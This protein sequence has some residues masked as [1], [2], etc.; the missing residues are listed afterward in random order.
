MKRA[1]LINALAVAALLTC[2]APLQAADE[3]G[4][5][6]TPLTAGPELTALPVAVWAEAGGDAWHAGE[7]TFKAE[8]EAADASAVGWV[9]VN[10]KAILIRIAVGD[11]RHVGKSGKNMW[12][13]DCIQLGVIPFWSGGKPAPPDATGM[14]KAGGSFCFSLTDNGPYTWVYAHSGTWGK[15]RRDDLHAAVTRDV[16]AKT[17]TYDIAIPWTEFGLG[18]AC[19][20]VLGVTVQVNDTDPGKEQERLYWGDG[21]GG[22]FDPGKFKWLR[23]GSPAGEFAGVTVTNRMLCEAHPAAESIVALTSAR[24]CTITVSFAGAKQ[25]LAVKARP[26]LRFFSVKATPARPL[27]GSAAFATTVAAAGGDAL[28][29]AEATV[30]GDYEGPWYAFKPD[31]DSGPSAIGMEDWLE[32]PAGVHGGVRMV[33]DHFEFDDGTRVKFWGLNHSYG[34]CAP[35]KGEADRRA[36]HYRKYGVNCIRL[37]KFTNYGNGIGAEETVTK[38][39]PEGLE[40]LDYYH[41]QL[42]KN[43]IYTGWSSIFALRLRPGDKDS[44]PAFDEV[45][46]VTKDNRGR[47]RVKGS[48]MGY[49]FINRAIQ[50]LHIQQTVNLLNHR[51]PHTGLTYADDPVLA[52][53]EFHN[54]DDIFWYSTSNMIEANPA[55]KKMFCEQF[56]DWLKK[57]YG[58]HAGLVEAWGEN[59]INAFPQWMKGEHLDKRNIYPVSNP[60]FMG[61]GVLEGMMKPHKRRILDTALFMYEQQLD[62]YRRYETAIRATGFKGS[63]VGS[64]WRAG[65]GVP[66]YYNLHT[67]YLVGHIDRHDYFGGG[68]GGH[69]SFSPNSMLG[70]PGS[71]LLAEGL[72]QVKDR[73]FALSEWINVNPHEW[74]AEG[75]AIIGVYAMGL[76]GWDASYEFNSRGAGFSEALGGRWDTQQPSAIGIYPAI[77]RMVL[78]GDVTEADVISARKVHVPSLAEGKL[79]FGESVIEGATHD[80]KTFTSDVPNRALAVGRV[81]VEFTKEYEPTDLT[82]IS[83]Y[84]NGNVTKSTTGELTWVVPAPPAGGLVAMSY[85]DP[86]GYFTVNAAGTKAVVGFAPKQPFKLGDVTITVDNLFAVVFVTSLEKDKGIADAGRLLVT[87]IARTKNTGMRRNAS[88]TEL[89]ER[90]EG[91]ILM[92]P[93]RAD[94]RLARL[95]RMAVNI[96]DHDGRRTG[97]TLP[98]SDG[99]FSIDGARDKTMYYEIVF[100]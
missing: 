53:V 59:S 62:F 60:W 56:S 24:D 23:P 17:T 55:H 52:Y 48:T 72:T 16:N 93:V 51:N 1:L 21:I 37:H 98:V 14:G 63:L 38:F 82:D 7:P 90:G 6:I 43:G 33:G 10:S 61:Q 54:E 73:P 8:G 77:S 32:A 69:T 42:K 18:P 40:R 57:K 99:G 31:N 86:Q 12:Q 58:S 67:D 39:D 84:V 89:L 2:P 22:K 47:V 49:K 13:G 29:S 65:S 30:M 87:A 41:A 76:Q 80:F 45:M 28:A 91:P 75:P 4:I 95:G 3:P 78:R 96:L 100:E 92:E 11:D 50:D 81:V 64:C 71:G 68:S 44:V 26:G 34:G 9:A 88:H 74:A 94:I 70:Q 35:E 83:R 25:M 66:H 20:P 79:D 36:K 97:R 15:G 27:V 19:C 5:E 46:K 85:G